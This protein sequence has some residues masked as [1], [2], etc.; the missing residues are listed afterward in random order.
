MTIDK[1]TIWDKGVREWGW[2]CRVDIYFPDGRIM[3]DTLVFKNEP[4]DNK[5]ANAV[6]KIQTKAEA[7]DPNAVVEVSNPMIRDSLGQQGELD[8]LKT[9]CIG[10][11]VQ[12]VKHTRHDDLRIKFTDDSEVVFATFGG[13]EISELSDRMVIL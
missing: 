7:F 1:V 12:N 6:A 9:F 10:K 8:R 4:S 5:L 13:V 11:T 2:M 3:H